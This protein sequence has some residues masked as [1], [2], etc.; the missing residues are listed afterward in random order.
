[1]SNQMRR[2]QINEFV[3]DLTESTLNGNEK[4]DHHEDEEKRWICDEEQQENMRMS[5]PGC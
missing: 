4:S 1:M 2:D 5:L 3:S